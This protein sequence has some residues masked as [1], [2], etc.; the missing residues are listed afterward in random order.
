MKQ[1]KC[2]CHGEM[3]NGEEM[4]KVEIGNRI[5]YYCSEE[6]YNEIVNEKLY[7]SHILDILKDLNE[8]FTNTKTLFKELKSLNVS[9]KKIFD[10]MNDLFYTGFEENPYS[11]LGNKIQHM[12]FTN[13]Y[14]YVKYIIA[15]IR[16]SIQ[17]N[18]SKKII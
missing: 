14:S 6:I 7:K 12:K 10:I 3:H 2:K 16:T 5:I 4:F 11:Q 18:N 13:N 9:Y 17:R 1:V 8:N 15:C